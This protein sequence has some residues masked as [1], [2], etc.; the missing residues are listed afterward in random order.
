MQRY[1]IELLRHKDLKHFV[2]YLSADCISCTY[3]KACEFFR[4][5]YGFGTYYL[6]SVEQDS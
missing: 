3:Y 1:R 5:S 4:N 2:I 6:I